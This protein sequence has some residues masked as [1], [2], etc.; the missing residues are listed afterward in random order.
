ML[1]NDIIIYDNYSHLYIIII[2][3][4][5]YYYYYYYIF[6]INIFGR[7]KNHGVFNLS[8]FIIDLGLP[9]RLDK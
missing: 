7:C 2:I 5:Y 1:S 4:Y 9:H 8:L 3:L 6:V